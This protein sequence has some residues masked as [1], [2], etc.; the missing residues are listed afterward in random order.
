VVDGM[1]AAKFMGRL[2][3]LLEWPAQMM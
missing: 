1:L 2:K 3:E